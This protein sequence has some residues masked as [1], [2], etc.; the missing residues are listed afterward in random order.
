[1]EPF[2][3]LLAEIP[4]CGWP[5]I[6]NKTYQPVILDKGRVSK[7][8]LNKLPV[9][10]CVS[11]EEGWGPIH[12]KW[13]IFPKCHKWKDIWLK[14]WMHLRK[15]TPRIWRAIGLKMLPFQLE[16]GIESCGVSP[17][18]RQCPLLAQIGSFLTLNKH[19]WF[20]VR[21]GLM[22]FQTAEY[23]WSQLSLWLVKILKPF[24]WCSS[25]WVIRIFILLGVLWKRFS[26]L[27]CSGNNDFFSCLGESEMA[28]AYKFLEKSHSK[29]TCLY[30]FNTVFFKLI[31]THK[32]FGS[33]MSLHIW[34]LCS[35]K[36]S[37]GKINECTKLKMQNKWI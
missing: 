27:G 24:V 30:L 34:S 6:Q 12:A 8:S 19:H 17:S 16:R 7:D 36:D 13:F 10:E 11:L 32:S 9:D 20:C 15:C 21:G 37:L 4:S 18:Q 29:E 25:E 14:A 31:W 1:M 3:R 2:K 35:L 26:G 22:C 23:L 5:Q 33:I 28:S